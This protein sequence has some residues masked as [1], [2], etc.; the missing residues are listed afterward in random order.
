MYLNRGYEL[1]DKIG[2]EL[3]RLHGVIKVY[4]E[5]DL[6]R[7]YGW[8][9]SSVDFLVETPEDMVYI[10]VKYLSTRRKESVNINK[11]LSS[12]EYIRTQLHDYQRHKDTKGLWVSKLHPFDDNE[13]LLRSCG[14]NVVSCFDSMDTLVSK[15]LQ[16]L[17]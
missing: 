2:I 10:Q 17:V 1:E 14:V 7:L 13:T 6:T 15:T 5:R 8:P 3:T 12:I 11:F 4:T 16:C 9:A